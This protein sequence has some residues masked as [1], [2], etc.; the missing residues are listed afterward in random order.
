MHADASKLLLLLLTQALLK[1]C[2]PKKQG[3]KRKEP[4]PKK[5]GRK[6]K[7]PEPEEDG[8]VTHMVW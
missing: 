2:H 3:G 1:S 4:E 5:R 8:Q 7:E 6:R